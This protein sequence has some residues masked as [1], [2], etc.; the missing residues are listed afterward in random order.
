M[1]IDLA[2]LVVSME[3][4]T[5]KFQK[6]MDR[7]N[8][9][10]DQFARNSKRTS[11]TV[12]A[13]FAGIRIGAL[14]GSLTAFAKIAANNVSQQR[15]LA[16]SVGLT[17][18][19]FSALNY[20]A[21]QSELSQED[22]GRALFRLNTV[23][24]DAANGNEMAAE[25]L[26]KF[27]ISAEDV[28]SGVVGSEQALRRIADVFNGM[29][30]GINKSALAADLLGDKLGAK[31]IPFLSQGSAGLDEFARKGEAVGAV[32]TD[33]VADAVAKA[34]D[35][36]AAFAQTLQTQVLVGLSALLG[37]VESTEGDKAID[38]L[39]DKIAGLTSELRLLESQQGMAESGGILGALF[40]TDDA[41]R[42]AQINT[43]L[44]DLNKELAALKQK[45][46]DRLGAP[47]AA[48]GVGSTAPKKTAATKALEKDAE[49][50]R[51]AQEA[52]EE[53]GREWHALVQAQKDAEEWD[54]DVEEENNLAEMS[55]AADQ[56]ARNIQSFTASLVDAAIA[57]DDMG[58]VV[59]AAL[60]RM[61]AEMITLAI[62]GKVMGTQGKD[63]SY[64]GGLL[65]G[66]LNG[67]AGRADGGPV[68]G[69]T[70]YMVGE[71]GPEL[72]VPRNS[73]TIVPNGGFGGG[74][75]V[76]QNIDA[77][78]ADPAVMANMLRALD[79]SN[80]RLKAEIY[81]EQRRGYAPA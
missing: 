35:K 6:D 41:A 58:D 57:G 73:G 26:A 80:K 54:F 46:L 62:L 79:A 52:L 75:N 20:A 53:Y 5:A 22:L 71:R 74:L 45:Q 40:H 33:R 63:G 2:Q 77:R 7:V 43:E 49:A 61:A 12:S 47:T 10:L 25:T 51:K 29:P 48:P 32:M 37:L 44:R 78:G 42:I 4:N 28:R 65:S 36:L 17:A 9:K 50:A 56:A 34:N 68:S 11:D 60:R 16:E 55:A 64:T 31:L 23:L 15:A 8:G 59:V 27:G 38:E 19:Q 1:A 3:A 24:A 18:Q 13:A 70:P 66:F 14:V 72:F 81:E 30:A 69:G 21:R 76:T 67:L 39:A